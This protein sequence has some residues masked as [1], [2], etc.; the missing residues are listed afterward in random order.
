MVVKRGYTCKNILE[1]VIKIM[2]TIIILKYE[3]GMVSF[4]FCL[5]ETKA[6][7]IQIKAGF[8][9][10]G[11]SIKHLLGS[12]LNIV[13]MIVQTSECGKKQWDMRE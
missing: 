8:V 5:G 6:T 13:T 9:A 2:V 12:E 11:G 1:R 4:S 7:G 3:V 10:G